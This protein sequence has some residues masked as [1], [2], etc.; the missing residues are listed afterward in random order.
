MVALDVGCNNGASVQVLGDNG[1][2]QVVE[3]NGGASG[4]KA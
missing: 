3:D 2:V 1:G 4:A